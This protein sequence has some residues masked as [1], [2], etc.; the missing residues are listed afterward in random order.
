MILFREKIVFQYEA[1]SSRFANSAPCWS[2]AK[3]RCNALRTCGAIQ[4][5]CMNH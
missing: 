3:L 1:V 5:D 4:A 2:P